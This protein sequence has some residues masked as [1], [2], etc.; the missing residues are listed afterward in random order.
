MGKN[1][2]KLE[3]LEN[4]R[5]YKEFLDN[6]NPHHQDI[7]E[8]RDRKKAERRARDNKINL[9]IYSG[10]VSPELAELLEDE[11]EDEEMYFKDPETLMKIFINFEENNL[12]LISQTSEVKQALEE[13]KKR[14]EETK[15]VLDA[16]KAELIQ[17]RNE[18]I[19]QEELVKEEIERLKR[20]KSSSEAHV[21]LKELYTEIP[22]ICKGSVTE[23]VFDPFDVLKE[24]EKDL[25]EKT[26]R[27]KEARAEN[28]DRVKEI[29]KKIPKKLHKV[30]REVKAPIQMRS[31]EP[32]REKRWGR[33]IMAKCV[34]Q[35]EVKVEKV[36]TTIPEEELERRKY[37]M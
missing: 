10:S 33:P 22:R 29:E 7:K 8:R 9:E 2:T 28:E 27:I 17:H 21:I 18:N 3:Q 1:T 26:R 13:F 5:K 31:E 25:E 34:L 23:A 36:E 12:Y 20:I 30:D 19:R 16:K 15:R 11:S 32:R 6:L 37:L 35:E 14:A 4:A 24:V